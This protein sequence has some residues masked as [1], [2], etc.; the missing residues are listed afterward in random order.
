VR[1]YFHDTM[2]PGVGWVVSRN[3]SDIKKNIKSSKKCLTPNL[4]LFT[5]SLTEGH[6]NFG[7]QFLLF[8]IIGHNGYHNVVL[9]LHAMDFDGINFPWAWK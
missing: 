3:I 6:A 5:A 1:I 8:T 9:I 2:L 7:L 4:D